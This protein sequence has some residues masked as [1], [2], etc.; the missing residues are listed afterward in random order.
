MSNIIFGKPR[1]VV[2]KKDFDE[3]NDVTIGVFF[4]G[5][6]NNR[7]NIEGRRKNPN[8][9]KGLGNVSFGN[10]NTNVDKL[11][12]AYPDETHYFS[13]YVEGIGTKNPKENKD[14]S[15]SYYGDFTRGQAGGK[16]ETGLYE[17]VEK[18]CFD[19]IRKLKKKNEENISTLYIDVFGFSR[20]AA[21]AR[22][23]VN[24]LYKTKD[25]GDSASYAMGCLGKA[26]KEL[27]YKEKPYRIKIRLLG[28]YDTVSSY[29]GN[30]FD[31]ITVDKI[32][33]HIPIVGFTVHLTAEDE[34]REKFPLTNIASAGANSKEL[35]LPGVHSDIG[36]GYKNKEWEQ[37]ILS[38]S[39][40]MLRSEML[41]M[42]EQ[43]WFKEK[44]MIEHFEFLEGNRF[45]SNEYSLVILHLMAEFGKRKY[46]IPWDYRKVLNKEYEIPSALDAIKKRLDEYAF[47]GKPKMTFFSKKELEEKEKRLGNNETEIDKFYSQAEDHKMLMTLR[48]KYLHCSASMDGIG[49]EPRMT[50]PTG[51]GSNSYREII[52][53]RFIIN[54]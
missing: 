41:K 44:E 37:T 31:D 11:Q 20:G 16:G 19:L 39:S 1:F 30:V 6:S 38:E 7:E 2:P 26:F 21:A 5:T 53:E 36:G 22:I 8:L 17:K 3:R 24:E 18:G 46:K 33:L 28:L 35:Y 14:G 48:N 13:I 45:P 43:G 9:K 10:D 27:D 25:S 52:W 47:E 4:D 29:G 32:P 34:H 49:M 54:G 15:L 42:Q 12:K 51:V 40:H 23:F 50:K